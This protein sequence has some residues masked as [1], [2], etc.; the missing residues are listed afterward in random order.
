MYEF[1]I[2][3]LE[4][5]HRSPL[6]LSFSLVSMLILDCHLPIFLSLTPRFSV[7]PD[8]FNNILN[9]LYPCYSNYLSTDNSNQ[10]LYI[11]CIQ[12]F[13]INYLIKKLLYTNT[14]FQWLQLFVSPFQTSIT[15]LF[16]LNPISLL[17]SSILGYDDLINFWIPVPSSTLQQTACCMS[18]TFHFTAYCNVLCIHMVLNEKPLP[19]SLK[20][21]SHVQPVLVINGSLK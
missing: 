19:L 20:R 7:Y 5:L 2:T 11:Y 13:F 12:N 3:S 21:T 18:W 4:P 1:A 10:H 15:S 17:L 6:S 14:L 16:F 8:L 9:C